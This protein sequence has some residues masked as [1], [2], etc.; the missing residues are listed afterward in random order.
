MGR[1]RKQ[2]S[3]RADAL[4][5][6]QATSERDRRALCM[7]RWPGILAAITTLVAAY[8]DGAGL[9]LLTIGELHEGDDPGVT[10]TAAGGSAGSAI[11]VAV[12]ADTLLVHTSRVPTGG[13]HG[14]IRTCVIDG[15]RSDLAVA[16][17]LLQNWMDHL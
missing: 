7:Q 8:N 12:E 2:V 5:A 6:A 14:S 17:Y 11:T 10:I 1:R 15:S 9:Q 4:A 16:A 3:D 13:L